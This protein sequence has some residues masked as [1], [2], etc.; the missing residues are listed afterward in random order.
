[1]DER[2]NRFCESYGRLRSRVFGGAMQLT[3]NESGMSE[4]IPATRLSDG[5]IRFIAP[6]AM[7]RHPDPPDL[8]CIEE[9]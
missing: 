6:L 9:P 1:M 3:V 5:A 7:L 4:S 2:L 8:V